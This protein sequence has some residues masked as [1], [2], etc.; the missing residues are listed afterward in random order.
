MRLR[1]Q[2]CEIWL[3]I[4]QQTDALLRMPPTHQKDSARIKL[5]LVYIHEHYAEKLPIAELAQAAHLSERECY[6]TFQDALHTTPTEYLT[7]YRLQV[8]C[9][10]LT[11]SDSSIT[12]ISQLCGFGSSSYFGKI[13]ARR[14]GC[15][16]LEYRQHRQDCNK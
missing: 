13:F 1:S 6:R 11:R 4:L 3:R 16:P 14:I 15:T 7:R 10:M 2:L 12:T 9:Q 8:A 5:M